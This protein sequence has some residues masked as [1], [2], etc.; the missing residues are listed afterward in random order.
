MGNQRVTLAQFLSIVQKF[1]APSY[2][3]GQRFRRSAGRG[4]IERLVE[5]LL[6][7]DDI[8]HLDNGNLLHNMAYFLFSITFNSG[9]NHIFFAI[10]KPYNQSCTPTR[11]TIFVITR[12]R[13]EYL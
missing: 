7:G 6:R 12:L 3:Y 11:T 5:Y 2:Y 13:R 10:Y 1:H 9:I 4:D 8:P